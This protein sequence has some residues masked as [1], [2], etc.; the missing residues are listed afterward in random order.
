MLVD[1]GGDTTRNLL[2]AG[3]IALLENPDQFAWLKADLPNRLAGAREELLRWTTPV[4]YMRRT[5]KREVEGW[6]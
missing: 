1:A 4:I 2:S 3:L 5:A 6:R